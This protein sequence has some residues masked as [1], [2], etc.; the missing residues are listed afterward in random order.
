MFCTNTLAHI[1]D[2]KMEK[3]KKVSLC[4]FL[5]DGQANRSEAP[6]P[7]SDSSISSMGKETTIMVIMRLLCCGVLMC[8]TRVLWCLF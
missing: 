4:I 2:L 1:K 3:K 6:E 8:L 5:Q 7:D